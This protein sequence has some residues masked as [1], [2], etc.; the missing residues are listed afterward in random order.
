MKVSIKDLS[1]N[2]DIKSKGIELD[3]YSADGKTHLGDL[4]VTMTGLT[5]C[6]GRTG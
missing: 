5:W 2:M 3:V 1:V 4:V 6:K